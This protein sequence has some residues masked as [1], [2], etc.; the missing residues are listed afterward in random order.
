[1]RWRCFVVV[2]N[3]PF[4][5]QN[6]ICH[7]RP[8]YI[9][10]QNLAQNM[11]Y[12]FEHSGQYHFPSGGTMMP[13]H[14]KWNHSTGQSDASQPIIS[15]TSSCGLWHTQYSRLSVTAGCT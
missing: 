5:L 15:L 12:R 7:S 11:L 4:S 9:L 2:H 6:L 1:M 10:Y 8:V 13:T 3:T 14:S